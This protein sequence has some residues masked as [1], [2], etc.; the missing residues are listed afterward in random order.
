[1]A[2]DHDN[3]ER[4]ERVADLLRSAA[5]RERAPETLQTRVS[6]MQAQAAPTRRRTML[7]RRAFNYVRIA[8]PATAAG[9]AALVLALGSSAGAP[10]LAQAASLAARA[11][12]APAPAPDP[13]DPGKLL[14][15]RVG[16]L[17]FPNWTKVGGWRAVGQ[18]H[19]RI[20]NRTATTVYYA[21]GSGRVAYSIV[22]SPTLAMKSEQLPRTGPLRYQDASTLWSHGRLTVI[23][24]QEGHTCLLTGSHGMTAAQ[25][26]ALAFH[27]FRLPLNR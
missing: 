27:G 5:Q 1:M 21:T 6:A 3:P 4:A 18:R 11:P 17:H 23:W 25:L 20:G 19:D 16:T 15:A 2:P 10:S 7:P 8:M 22:S 13:G 12:T 24:V 26:W 14:S 9:V